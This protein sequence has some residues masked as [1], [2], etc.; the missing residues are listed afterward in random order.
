M[1]EMGCM[2]SWCRVELG[3]KHGLA[4]LVVISSTEN[5]RIAA[6]AGPYYGRTSLP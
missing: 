1:R 6:H 5:H 4:L 2:D 3:L